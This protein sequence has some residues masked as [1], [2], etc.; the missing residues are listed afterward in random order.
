MNIITYDQIYIGGFI[1]TSSLLVFIA[2]TFSTVR[3]LK[4]TINALHNVT[5]IQAEQ[6]KIKTTYVEKMEDDKW[7]SNAVNKRIIRILLSSM[8]YHSK[9]T[10][11]KLVGVFNPVPTRGRPSIRFAY[12]D[13]ENPSILSK[14]FG[15]N[16]PTTKIIPGNHNI[17]AI[18]ADSDNKRDNMY[19]TNIMRALC[20][21]NPDCKKP[22]LTVDKLIPRYQGYVLMYCDSNDKSELHKVIYAMS[23]YFNTELNRELDLATKK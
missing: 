20:I 14:Y 12:I 22:S 1:F 8:I 9:Q 3:K 7:A 23:L 5:V 2:L 19:A 16:T 11:L 10:N 6:L 15:K 13:P 18:S 17:R 4:N 21:S